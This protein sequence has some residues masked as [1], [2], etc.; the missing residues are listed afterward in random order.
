MTSILVLLALATLFVLLVVFT[1]N[2]RFTSG[3]LPHDR[4]RHNDAWLFHG[5]RRIF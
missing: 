2:D 3:P 1:R 4:F 5:D